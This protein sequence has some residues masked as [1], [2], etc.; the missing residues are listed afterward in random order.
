MDYQNYEKFLKLWKSSYKGKDFYLQTENS[1][2]WP[3]Y[4][5]KLRLNNSR[6]LEKKT[7]EEICTMVYTLTLCV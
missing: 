6:Y 1:D 3:L 5:S 2:E 4:F 7:L